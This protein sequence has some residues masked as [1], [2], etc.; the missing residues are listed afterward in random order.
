MN[1]QVNPKQSDTI[2]KKFLNKDDLFKALQENDRRAQ[3]QFFDE[4]YPKL[5]KSS[6]RIVK[7]RED[8]REIA[9]NRLE[10]YLEEVKEMENYRQLIVQLFIATKRLSLNCLRDNKGWRQHLIDPV[11]L[12][13][14]PDKVTI[15]EIEENKA[16]VFVRS[17][18]AGHS[19]LNRS[20]AELALFEELP[21]PEIAKSLHITEK[22]VRTRKSRILDK[23]RKAMKGAGF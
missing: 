22:T 15:N 16:E 4:V 7:D 20:I 21:N 1:H 11:V 13:E 17:F 14:L 23:L 5:C 2:M 3:R 6:F 10:K 12:N 9:S 18:L 19:P 8:A